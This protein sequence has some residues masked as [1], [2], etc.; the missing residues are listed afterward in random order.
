VH[1]F[2]A[3][4]KKKRKKENILILTEFFRVYIVVE[5]NRFVADRH[6]SRGSSRLHQPRMS[7]LGKPIHARSV[8]GKRRDK[9]YRRIQNV[10][11]NFLERPRGYK[12]FSYHII[13]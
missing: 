13:V 1:F 9:R 12:A 8:S 2:P 4:F 3:P 10:I 7:L 11:Y 5:H 6:S